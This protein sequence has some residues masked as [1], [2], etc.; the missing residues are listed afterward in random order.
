[1]TIPK[2]G[3]THSQYI[4]HL[5]KW[6]KFYENDETFQ[7]FMDEYQKE[8]IILSQLVLDPVIAIL[9]SLYCPINY[10]KH[11]DPVCM[12]RAFLLMALIKESSITK[13]VKLTRTSP[14]LPSW[15]DSIPTILPA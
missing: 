12:L 5:K 1:M 9:E 8:L 14:F 4:L 10:S 7:K 11:R 3:M 13:W 2:I 6:L 15:Q